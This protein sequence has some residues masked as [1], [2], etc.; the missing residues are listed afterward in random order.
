ME[1]GLERAAVL[2]GAGVEAGK[3]VSVQVAHEEAL[4]GSLGADGDL[5]RSGGAGSA[6]HI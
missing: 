5:S 4:A 2:G 1:L 3:G 6:C